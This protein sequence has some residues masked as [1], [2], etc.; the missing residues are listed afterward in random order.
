MRGACRTPAWHAL[1]RAWCG[2]AALHRSYPALRPSDVPFGQDAVGDQ[3][4]LRDGRVHRLDGETGALA[5]LGVG[6]HDF[7]AAVTADP[8]ETLALHPLL[9][10]QREGGALAPGQ[11]L[12]VYPPFCTAEAAA[13]VSLRAVA[14]EER[15]GFL[16]R[17]AAH[18]A[19][20]G[21]G[22]RV[23]LRVTD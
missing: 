19:G 15:L 18:L 12:N 23:R 1:G 14:A 10:F 13:G 3:F 16:A 20:R 5:D 8:V 6:L 21:D 7:L 4:I 2:E 22:D 17:F 11:L 9:Q